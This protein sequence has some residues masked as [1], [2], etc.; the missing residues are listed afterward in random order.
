MHMMIENRLYPQNVSHDR[1]SFFHMKKVKPV[2]L[3][4][5]RIR[6]G[7]LDGPPKCF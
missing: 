1:Q 3:D 6:H 2:R 4:P 7:E 5:I